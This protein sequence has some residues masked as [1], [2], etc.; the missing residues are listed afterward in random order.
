MTNATNK[1]ASPLHKKFSL[2]ISLKLFLA[3]WIVILISVLISYLVTMQFRHSPSQEQAN[4]QQLKLLSMYTEK[5]ANKKQIKLK[6]I[7]RSFDRKHHQMLIIKKI[8]NNKVY[9]PRKRGWIE[10]KNYLEKHP[11]DNPVTIDFDFTKVT[12]SQPIVINGEKFQLFI[13]SEMRR[14][15]IVSWVTQ[16]PLAMRLIMLLLVSFLSCWLL[17]KSFTKPLIAL[18]KASE[19]IGKGKLATRITKF[20]QRSDEFGALARSFN[21]MAE[22]LENNITAHQRLLGDVSH[23]LRSPLTRLQLA[24]ALAEKNMGNSVEQQKHLNRCETEVDRLDEMIADVLT[25]SRLEH[26]QNVFDADEID[27]KDLVEYVVND[28]Q[29]FATSKNVTIDFKT[30]FSCPLLADS[31]LVASAISNVVNNAVKYS[32]TNQVVTL[33]LSEKD[34]QITLTISDHGPG[35][36][37]EMIEKLFTPFFRVAD[38]RERSSGGTGLGLAIAQQAITLH[39]GYIVAQN[40]VSSGLK[41]IITLPTLLKQNKTNV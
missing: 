11:L 33:E 6:A 39:Q 28:C 25:L 19:S 10:V 29:Y 27:L 37:D 34:E 31:K 36:P 12:S 35:V 22:Q 17:A 18:Q 26:N 15:R 14:K 30:E 24:V 1:L 38:G 3:F 20:E 40:Q 41:V 16:L 7:Q 13:A 23:E 32:P 2:G 21:Q 8:S 9:A 5:L 4:P